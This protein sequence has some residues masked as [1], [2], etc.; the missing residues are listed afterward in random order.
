[1]KFWKNWK[2]REYEI[3]EIKSDDDVSD[4]NK[5]KLRYGVQHFK[6]LNKELEKLKIDE[7]YHFHFFSPNSYDVFFDHLRNGKLIP[8]DFESDFGIS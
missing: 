4:E 8:Y 3:I 2:K 5:A 7:K 1:M 6:D